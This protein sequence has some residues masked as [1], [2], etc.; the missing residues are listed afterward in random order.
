MKRMIARDLLFAFAF[1]CIMAGYDILIVEGL[2]RKHGLWSLIHVYHQATWCY[3]AFAL[4]VLIACAMRSPFFAVYALIMTYCGLE[5]IMYFLLQL[6][7]PPS[8][9]PWLSFPHQAPSLF[10]LACVC[11]LLLAVAVCVHVCVSR[12]TMRGEGCG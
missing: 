10:E 3:L 12:V 4:I 8:S 6:K 9:F 2:F 7:L 1:T 11:A 5:D